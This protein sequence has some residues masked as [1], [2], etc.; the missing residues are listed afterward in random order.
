MAQTWHN[1]GNLLNDGVYTYTYDAANRL[2]GASS[3]S[4]VF[5]YQYSGL[6]DRMRHRSH[7]CGV[8]SYM[9]V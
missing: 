7:W 1:N 4:S 3:Q 6:G 9:E 5:S 8:M 2:I